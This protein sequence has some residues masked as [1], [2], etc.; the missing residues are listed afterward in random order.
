MSRGPAAALAASISIHLALAGGAALHLLGRQDGLE[1]EVVV[2]P[3][4]SVFAREARARRKPRASPAVPETAGAPAVGMPSPESPREPEGEASPLAPI[5][6]A[7][8]AL[9]RRLGEEG[10]AA[11]LLEINAEGHVTQATLENSSGHSRLDESARAALLLARFPPAAASIRKRMR[12]EF[13]LRGR[14]P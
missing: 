14:A 4:G 9:S 13:R 1:H 12:V 10:E 7:Y 3:L 6:P 8:P 2:A 11:F 5:R